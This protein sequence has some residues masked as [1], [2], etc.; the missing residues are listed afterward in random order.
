MV[1]FENK[2]VAHAYLIDGLYHLHVDAS[3][4]VNEQ[5]VN[6]V[7]ALREDRLNKLKKDSLL[8]SLIS[9]SYP[10]CESCLQ[11]KMAK[12]SFVGHGKEPLSY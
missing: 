8:G 5:I 10:I 7:W 1:Y 6:A 4:N 11:E 9:E 2:C 12:L 3:I